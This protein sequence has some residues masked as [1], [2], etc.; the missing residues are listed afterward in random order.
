MS[1]AKKA[2]PRTPGLDPPATAPAPVSE[3]DA[4]THSDEAGAGSH[5]TEGALPAPDGTAEPQI[6]PVA[7]GPAEARLPPT[8]QASLTSR[9]RRPLQPCLRS[10]SRR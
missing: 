9:S 3:P 7:S 8:R 2:S 4:S 10:R 1:D 5:P 6:A